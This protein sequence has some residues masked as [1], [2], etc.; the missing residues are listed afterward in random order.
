MLRDASD[1]VLGRD[2]LIAVFGHWPSFH[3]AEVVWLRMDRRPPDDG[4]DWGP[5]VDTMIHVFEHLD[6]NEPDGSISMLRRKH[7]LVHFR[8]RDVVDLR[9]QGFNNQNYL[10]E[11]TIDDLRDRQWE[12]IHFQVSMYGSLSASFQCHLV[13]VV[14]VE[15]C[16]EHGQAVGPS[17]SEGNR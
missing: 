17:M 8:F 11:M 14:S 10:Q 13:E 1:R 9:L 6:V 2:L 12:Y 15:P 3:D 4:E 7:V 5:T 16:D